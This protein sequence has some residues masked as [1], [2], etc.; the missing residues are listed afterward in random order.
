MCYPSN[1]AKSLAE[2]C[3]GYPH[4]LVVTPGYWIECSCSMGLEQKG[5]APG[6]MS[7]GKSRKVKQEE[8]KELQEVDEG[9]RLR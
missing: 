7:S 2:F 9:V 8:D 3:E 1:D 6:G 4:H 5:S